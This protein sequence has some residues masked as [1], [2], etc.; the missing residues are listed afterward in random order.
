VGWRGRGCSR[1]TLLTSVVVCWLRR[2]LILG[3]DLS[4]SWG[5]GGGRCG[6]SLGAVSSAAKSPSSKTAVAFYQQ[7]RSRSLRST[8]RRPGG[9]PQEPAEFPHPSEETAFPESGPRTHA[10][11]SQCALQRFGVTGAYL[12]SWTKR[13]QTLFSAALGLS[14]GQAQAQDMVGCSQK[15]CTTAIGMRPVAG[16]HSR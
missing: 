9:L 3:L 5:V 8:F 16:Q 7:V 6:R 10:P 2:G 4:L 11:S 13:T 12:E 1:G 15:N 14:W